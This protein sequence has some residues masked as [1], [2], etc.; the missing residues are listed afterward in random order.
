MDNLGRTPSAPDSYYLKAS[1]SII[2]RK[3]GVISMKK[4]YKALPAIVFVAFI[5][6]MLILFLVLP[7]RDFSVPEKRY[8]EKAPAFT[9][10]SF[11]KTEDK[12]SSFQTHFESFIED[13]TA[14]RDFWVE[15]S[16]YYNLIL[17]NNGA[18]GVY[19]G[20]DGYLINDPTETEKFSR[21]L[22]FIEEFAEHIARMKV[23]VTV[24][25]AP[26][27]GYV[28]EDKLPDLHYTYHDDELFA[29]MQDTFKTAEFVDLREPLKTAYNDGNQVFYRTDHHWTSF[30][31]F[32]AYQ[33]LSK[34]L[35]YTPNDKSAYEVTSYEGF[36]GTTYSTSGYWLTKPDDIEI[37]D[38]PTTKSTSA[39][40]T[41]RPRIRRTCSSTAT[42]RS[43][44]NTPCS[45]TATI[46][47]RSSPTR[48]P[49]PTRS[50]WSSRTALPIRWYR[51][52]RITM[53][54]SSWWICAT[55]PCPCSRS[56]SMRAST[57]CC[58]SIP[59]ITS[60]PTTTSG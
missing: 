59:S 31:A 54:R 21:N 41:A 46:P 42:S 23:P 20:K 49:R 43:R 14:G 8:L 60:R 30:G 52:S 22:G 25:V 4:V 9:L 32:T 26:S 36:Y 50:C 16:A 12:E 53:L 56:S 45:S 3:E 15:L 37:W 47:T 58:S 33:A 39:S 18:K 24:A 11:F 10:S 1:V 28:C 35:G 7:K 55:I 5:G 27:T 29:E 51:S 48:T 17:G 6:V 2:L 34:S 57:A 44:T 13:H 19:H 40:S 38:T